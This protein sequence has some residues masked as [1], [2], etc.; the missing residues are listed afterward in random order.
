MY[1]PRT[2]IERLYVKRENGG[3][4]LIQEITYKTTTLGLKKILRYN[5]RLDATVCKYTRKA[6]KKK[7]S[8]RKWSN[9]CTNHLTL[10]EISIKD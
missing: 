6:K 5:N 10:K 8:I 1:H 4:G 7:Y 9:K 2:D 3:K